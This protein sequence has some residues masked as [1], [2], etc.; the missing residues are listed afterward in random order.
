MFAPRRDAHQPRA[1]AAG[2]FGRE[3]RRA[4]ETMIATDHQHVAEPPLVGVAGARAERSDAI[5][6]RHPPGGSLDPREH[7]P[8]HAEIPVHDFAR[9]PAAFAGE[10]PL[11]QADEGRGHGGAN[12][13]AER[14]AGIGVDPGRNVEGQH[15]RG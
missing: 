7:V 6:E 4:G 15:R 9:T 13:L 12:R 10:Q 8:G 1:G 5:L 14:T 11:L 3:T 2:G